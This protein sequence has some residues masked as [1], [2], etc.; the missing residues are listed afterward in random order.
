MK[1]LTGLDQESDLLEIGCNDGGFIRLLNEKGF[2]KCI[3]IEP[4]RDAYEAARE[5]D[6]EVYNEMFPSQ[7]S[8]IADKLEHFDAVICRQVL[9]HI[10]DLNEFLAGI[11]RYLKDEGTL[12]L[13]IPDAS[14]N[15]DYVDYALWE[16]HVNYF[17]V[18]TVNTLLM[19]HGFH[20]LHYE[21]T[22]FSGKA[23][24]LFAQKVKVTD[25]YFNQQYLPK[26][27]EWASNWSFFKTSAQEF[28]HKWESVAVY[29]CGNRSSTFVNCCELENVS[30]F[31]DDQVEKQGLFVPGRNIEISEWD[32][33]WR[34]VPILFGVNT[35]NELRVIQRRQLLEG[36]FFSILPPSRY[37]PSFWHLMGRKKFQIEN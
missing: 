7:D 13:E 3:G 2:T 4:A 32:E 23:L 26:I 8:K 17:T 1:F 29:G 35:E 16:E 31:I 33:R 19:K 30:V 10:V 9:E 6:C 18:E 11:R 28:F 37:L 24:I 20:L 36:S 5:N 22:L 14:W 34:E 15:I 21:T 12:I 25:I 27:R